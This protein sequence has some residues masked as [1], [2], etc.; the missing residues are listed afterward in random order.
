MAEDQQQ[1]KT[2]QATAKRRQD[3][4]K[5]GQV[6]QSKEVNTAALIGISLL[7][8][9]FYAP[10]FW[11]Q[12]ENLLAGSLRRGG[13][14]VTVLSTVNLA[15]SLG[16]TLA[17][18]LLPVFMLTLLVGFLS[19]YMQ[20]GPLFTTKP[21]EPDLNKLNPIKGMAKFV[22]VRSAVELVKSLAK[23]ILVGVVAYRTVAAEF[24]KALSLSWMEL[25]QTLSFLG[26]VSFLVLL[27]TSGL[28]IVL[29]LLDYLFVRWEM[30][31]K[32]RM[33]K[34]ETKEEFKETEGDPHVKS[35]IR[36][37]QMRMARQRMM[38]EVPKADVVVTNPT[39]LSVALSYVRGE[40]SAPKVVAKGADHLAMRIREIA[41]EN[42]VP[43]VENVPVARALYQVEVGQEIPEEMFRGVAEI[44]AYVY[45]LKANSGGADK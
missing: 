24:E 30:E 40:M 6:A 28:L 39:H 8:W 19:C 36:S 27:K 33:T 10:I 42:G 37:I 5:K 20:V 18:L 17:L 44:L 32:M 45:G 4:R 22:S 16:G 3:F 31:K 2:E 25:P 21:M 26:H 1:E 38:A 15:W 23:I 11:R 13:S 29:A 9:T 41:G 43:L 7:M 34:Q 14:E 35:R 12:I